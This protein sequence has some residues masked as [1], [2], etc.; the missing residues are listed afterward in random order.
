MQ[1][2]TKQL[3]IVLF[4]TGINLVPPATTRVQSD[5]RLIEAVKEALHAMEKLQ[6]NGGWAMTWTA[7]CSGT[8]G[9]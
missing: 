5:Q 8:Y 1:K 7:Y 9:E 6:K 3:A 4:I 2:L